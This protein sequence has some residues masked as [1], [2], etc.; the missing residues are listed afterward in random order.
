MHN[1]YVTKRPYFSVL[2][3]FFDPRPFMHANSLL[4][5]SLVKPYKPF[6]YKKLLAIRVS[7]LQEETL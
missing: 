1:Y 2:R 5:F 4:E 6:L 7:R 3:E